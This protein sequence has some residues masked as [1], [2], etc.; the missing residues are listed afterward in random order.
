MDSKKHFQDTNNSYQLRNVQTGICIHFSKVCWWLFEK[1]NKQF[2]KPDTFADFNK[3]RD[4]LHFFYLHYLI[5]F[6]SSQ[7]DSNANMPKLQANFILSVIN[8]LHWD[9][10]IIQTK[11]FQFHFFGHDKIFTMQHG[12][13]LTSK[14]IGTL[15]TSIWKVM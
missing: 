12:P 1:L 13:S 11:F 8:D 2:A 10:L 5:V 4:W 14:S 7:Y 6:G 9:M 15:W 3:T